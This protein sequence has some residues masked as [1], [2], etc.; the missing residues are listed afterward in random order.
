MEGGLPVSI[1]HVWPIPH[2]QFCKVYRKSRDS[3]EGQQEHDRDNTDKSV[4]QQTLKLT[5]QYLAL[6]VIILTNAGL[7][8][9]CYTSNG[10]IGRENP[11]LT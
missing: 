10:K 2:S 7:C 4:P 8:Q 1:H 9:V 11:P 3:P 6:L 5:D